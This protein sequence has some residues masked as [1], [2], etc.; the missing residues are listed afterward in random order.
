MYHGLS[1]YLFVDHRLTTALL[2]KIWHSGIQGVEL[3]CGRQHFDY[4]NKAQVAELGYWFKDSE[5][6]LHSIHSPIY[7]DDCWGQTGPDAVV[8]LTEPVKG[9]RIKI[10]DEVKRAIEVA[11]LVPFQYLVQHLGMNGAE[12]DPRRVDAAF[13]SLEELK[14]FGSPLGVELLLEN[15]PNE[16]STGAQLIEFLKFTHLEL[17]LCFDTGH[18]HMSEGI[19]AAYRAMAP[20]I[21]STHVHDNNGTEDIHLFPKFNKAGTIPWKSTMEL[22][23]SAGSQYPLLLELRED[24]ALPSLD[25]VRQVFEFLE[26]QV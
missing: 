23:N 13:A 6:K 11:E 8:D 9:K 26:G 18:A 15:T 2:D 22:L 24:P 12:N 17:N 1:T 16:L 21:R 20:L 14:V 7:S 4:R 25:S 5:L 3:F 10:V 19:E